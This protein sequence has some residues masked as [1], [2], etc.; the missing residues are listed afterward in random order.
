M[1]SK[2]SE[3]LGF[4]PSVLSS[5]NLSCSLPHP[6]PKNAE[7]SWTQGHVSLYSVVSTKSTVSKNNPRDLLHP[8]KKL[9]SQ[10]CC[11]QCIFLLV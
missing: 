6:L 2:Q 10:Y 11:H 7:V 1:S 8:L 5:P 9:L 4:P 3:L